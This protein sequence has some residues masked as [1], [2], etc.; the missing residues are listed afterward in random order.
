METIGDRVR[1]ARDSTGLNRTDFGK[2]V[3]MTGAGIG[4]I[5]SGTTK[6]PK[7]G[8]LLKISDR[9]KHNLRWLIAGKGPRYRHESSESIIDAFEATTEDRQKVV[10]VI[11]GIREDS[12]L[13]KGV[14]GVLEAVLDLCAPL[15][16]T[17]ADTSTTENQARVG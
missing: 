13:P 6:D 2:E 8:N 1:M 9:T 14:S 11:L 15:E 10:G 3:G 12:D 5:E 16:K 7:P 4:Q 17:E